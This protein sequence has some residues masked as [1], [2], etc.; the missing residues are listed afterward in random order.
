M[1]NG[2]GR[3]VKALGFGSEQKA[4][5]LSDPAIVDYIVPLPSVSGVTVTASSALRVPAVLHAIRLISENVGSIPCKLY[6]E[7]GDSKEVA[8][9]HAASR[10]AHRFANEWTSAGQLRIDLTADAILH[11]AGYA[12]VVRLNDGRPGEFH[13]LTPGR[14]QR[15]FKES[16]EPFYLVQ[17]DKGRPEQ[18]SFRD[19]LFM[20][21][22]RAASP[23]ALC[24]DGIGVAVAL[25]RH[26][27]QFFAG[28]ARPNGIVW[29]DKPLPDKTAANTEENLRRSFQ[30]WQED[31]SGLLILPDGWKYDAQTMRGTDAQFIENRLEQIN[32]IARAIGVPPTMLYQLDRGT[33]SNTEQ[34][35]AG[36]LQLCLKPWLDRW[37]DAYAITLLSEDEQDDHY[38]E[39]V[40]A[41]LERADA[42]ARAQIYSSAIASRWL[43]PNEVRA[44]ENL[45]SYEGGDEFANPHTTTTTTT[46]GPASSPAKKDVA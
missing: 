15:R 1:R 31:P 3:V 9:D 6:R 34:M 42:A 11:G 4:I 29:N 8:K 39:F 5:P 40:T 37:Q 32:E 46:T 21:S 10:L 44:R 14:V 38:F 36:F 35:A 41:D 28:G 18:L 30:R 17:P 27:S 23:V 16:G 45:P 24:K 33:W 2:F 13:R 12:R 43:N 22:F 26:A 7:E 25:E 20:P 19:V